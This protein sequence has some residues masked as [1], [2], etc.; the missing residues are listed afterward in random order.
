MD[1]AL[2][3]LIGACIA[4]V[5]TMAGTLV[6]GKGKEIESLW[7]ENRNLRVELQQERADRQQ[8]EARWA[9]QVDQLRSELAASEER[10]D[11]RLI[12]IDA[13]HHTEKAEL[14]ARIVALGGA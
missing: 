2:A 10:C 1:P 8:G 6:G 7:T 13:R 3:G 11:Q 5:V 14:Q 9:Q 12:E 4:G